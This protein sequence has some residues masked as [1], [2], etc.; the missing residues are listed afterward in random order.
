[1][2]QKGKAWKR[3]NDMLSSSNLSI[4]SRTKKK[5]AEIEMG[6]D[7]V[8]ITC[9]WQ[10]GDWRETGSQ[11]TRPNCGIR[12]GRVPRGLTSWRAGWL[13]A[14]VAVVRRRWRHFGDV[15]RRA[16]SFI[17]PIS[18]DA[19]RIGAQNPMWPVSAW[20]RADPTDGG[21][22]GGEMLGMRGCRGGASSSFFC[23]CFCCCW[24]KLGDICTC[25]SVQFLPVRFAIPR[26]GC[27]YDTFC[28]ICVI[29]IHIYL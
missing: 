21:W 6:D 22:G 5:H 18:D 11:R 28:F 15:A 23:Y 7:R 2:R 9:W 16:S 17:R 25:N 19:C 29:S 26:F 12:K 10:Y 4:G 24:A 14:T 8:S 1:M 13:C 20:I 27:C 3:D